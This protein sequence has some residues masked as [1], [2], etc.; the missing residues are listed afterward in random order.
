MPMVDYVYS[1]VL[2]LAARRKLS[3]ANAEKTKMVRAPMRRSQARR[4]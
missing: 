2:R 4:P 3:A 1:T